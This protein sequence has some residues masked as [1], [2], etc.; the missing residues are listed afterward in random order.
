MS[1]N[2]DTFGRTLGFVVAVCLVCAFLVSLSAVQLK[3]L[4]QANRLLDKQT[5]I[6][7][8]A[9]LLDFAG[10]DIVATYDRFVEAKMINLDTGEF[11]EGDTESFEERREARNLASSISLENDVAG[12]KRRANS[13]VIY[14][15][16]NGGSEIETVVLPIIGNGLWDLMYG[17]VGLQPD[18]NTVRSVIYSDHKE[19]PGLGALVTSEHWKSLWPGKK[20]LDDDYNVA[21]KIVKGGAKA[22]DVHGVDAVTGATLTSKG[23][24]NT[25]N[26]WFGKQ[27]YGPFIAKYANGGL[28]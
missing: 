10:K 12:I 25:L 23:V 27:G 9:G 16:R 28:K 17:F 8:A 13:A 20:M 4:Q 7:E 19:T 26:F 18:L 24:Q 6:L 3:P 1:S 11:I 5:K 21:I 2:K 15:V 22:G 14:I